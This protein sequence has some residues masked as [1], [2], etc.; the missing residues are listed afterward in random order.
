MLHPWK[1]FTENLHKGLRIDEEL[2][3][4][5][6]WPKEC[7]NF[8][9]EV[10]GLRPFRSFEKL[11]EDVEANWPFPQIF[12]SYS[13]NILAIQN[14]IFTFDNDYELT[15]LAETSSAGKWEVLD[16]YQYIVMSNGDQMWHWNLETGVFEQLVPSEDIP[17]FKTCA[18]F[19]GQAFVAN[20]SDWYGMNS[21]SIAW[22]NIGEFTLKPSHRNEANFTQAPWNGVVHKLRV[23]GDAIM[24]YGD[25]GVMALVPLPSAPHVGTKLLP[26]NGLI[27]QHA[28]DG[29]EHLHIYVDRDRFVWKIGRDM[30]PKRIGYREYMKRLNADDLTVLCDPLERRYYITDGQTCF[31]LTS[32][33]MS[34]VYQCPTSVYANR[35]YVT[36]ENGTEAFVRISRSGMGFPGH[37][38]LTF[39]DVE[40]T[41]PSELYILSE[42]EKGYNKM[43]KSNELGSGCPTLAGARIGVGAKF[44]NYQNAEI[45]SIRASIGLQGKNA[46][47]GKV[48]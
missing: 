33:G 42:N 28:A 27:S 4:R 22:S 15:L 39:V 30:M 16:Y 40:T 7:Y 1:D 46:V 43:V 35:A 18:N 24:A 10:G 14:Q 19:R 13:Y 17:L 26:A 44:T 9:V 41:N 37:K 6:L 20:L 2:G 23:L 36:K 12:W 48:E 21:A 11:F 38:I 47:R 8:E 25:R 29:D 31:L 3:R 5:A 34:E 45:T 32:Y